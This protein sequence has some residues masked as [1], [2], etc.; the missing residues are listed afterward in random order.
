MAASST[1]FTGASTP[2]ATGGMVY[3]R[4]RWY[5]PT[6]GRFLTQDPIGLAGGVNL[7]AYA[8]NDP[9]SFSDPFG[10][11][12]DTNI[13]YTVDG[14]ELSRSGTATENE[15]F[16]SYKGE[17]HGLDGPLSPNAPVSQVIEDPGMLDAT[18]KPLA[19]GAPEVDGLTGLKNNSTTGKPLDFKPVLG[20]TY[21]NALWAAG[22]GTFVH[23]DKVGNAAWGYYAHMRAHVPL[24][25]AKLGGQYQSL[26]A[27]HQ[28]D[29]PRD[30]QFI[31]RGYQIQ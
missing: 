28:M 13:T 2:N 17:V 11:A 30:Q 23:D 15:Y 20:K 8:G 7:Y 21:G 3:L 25:A 10:L 26:R 6:T 12:P 18:A 22:D 16:L 5:D 27:K 31:E 14:A 19:L 9:I 24:W 29:D 4:N 1:G